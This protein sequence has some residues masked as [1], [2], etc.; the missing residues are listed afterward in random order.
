MSGNLDY[1][2]FLPGRFEFA[3]KALTKAYQDNTDALNRT[4][5]H[6][7]LPGVYTSAPNI[8]GAKNIQFQTAF[9]S[10][11]SIRDLI[12]YAELIIP[13]VPSITDRDSLA[14]ILL[15]VASGWNELIV[16]D[17]NDLNDQYK[18]IFTSYLSRLN[19]ILDGLQKFL[20]ELASIDKSNPPTWFHQTLFD[21]L[22]PIL[23]FASFRPGVTGQSSLAGILGLSLKTV[24]TPLNEVL[25]PFLPTKPDPK[26]AITEAIQT[27]LVEAINQYK[28][29][30]EDLI[31]IFTLFA[32]ALVMLSDEQRAIVPRIKENAPGPK[33]TTGDQCVAA[34]TGVKNAATT[35]IHLLSGNTDSTSSTTTPAPK[36]FQVK[37][38]A[39][40]SAPSSKSSPIAPGDVTAAF[41]PPSMAS[42]TLPQMGTTTGQIVMNF[43]KILTLPFIDQL[44]VTDAN[45]GET[46]VY[47]VMLNCKKK[48]EKL[49][50]TTVSI[51]RDLNSYGLLQEL[52]LPSINA[53]TDGLSLKDFLD[54]NLPLVMKYGQDAAK[55]AADTQAL[56]DEFE[57][58]L[59]ILNKNLD[60]INKSITEN[61][62]KL[63]EAQK[64][65]DSALANSIINSILAVVY[66]SVALASLAM[67]NGSLAIGMGISAGQNFAKMIVDAVNAG[68]LA[69]VIGNLKS[70]IATSE[71]TR[72]KLQIIIPLFRSIITLMA[73]IHT[74]WETISDDLKDVQATYD[75]WNNP[76]W[77]TADTVKGAIENWIDVQL[78]CQRYI[79]LV[80]GQIG[81]LDTAVAFNPG[82]VAPK[83]KAN[84]FA[85]MASFA[86][87]PAAPPPP[88][89]LAVLPGYESVLEESLD[90]ANRIGKFRALVQASDV[91]HLVDAL[92]PPAISLGVNRSQLN[93]AANSYR[94]IASS[95]SGLFDDSVNDA[96]A[97]ASTITS[98][99]IPSLQTAISFYITFADGQEDPFAKGTSAGALD[100][101]IAERYQQLQQGS[102]LS[103]SAETVFLNFRS[104]SQLALNTLT[105]HVNELNQ[106]LASKEASLRDLQAEYDKWSWVIYWPIPP[107]I[108]AI[109]YI[110]IDSITDTTNSINRLKN[111]IARLNSTQAY[112]S[113]IQSVSERVGNTTSSLSQSWSDLTTKTQT[114][115]TYVHAIVI[116]PDT[117]NIIR[118][119]V[120]NAWRAF[121]NE[122]KRW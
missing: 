67:G 111:D 4:Y 84:A 29:M 13:L 117:E 1:S 14:A 6:T 108:G 58:W 8:V 17:L 109:I 95:L 73:T 90:P 47:N 64:A 3:L 98:T 74:V 119:I 96:N 46:S 27:H 12:S 55:I 120:Q 80:S 103:K 102:N 36:P 31:P 45:Q 91:N 72:D 35:F 110:I 30:V 38:L 33:P 21:T 11:D 87:T 37:D 15:P 83:L 50:E 71:D 89:D 76:N 48:Y 61:Q 51:V 2:S 121:S 122:L 79:S 25:F 70:I 106:Q 22:V 107:G 41:G 19:P 60:E 86:A 26:T 81:S 28:Q 10:L 32:D 93:D 53:P 77:F 105:R 57:G 52:I 9:R 18:A 65:Y 43:N 118:P 59:Q 42:Q 85:T 40:H 44:K 97:L 115:E 39:V 7:V 82:N 78:Q 92:S 49:Q 88:Y 63:E 94:Q 75:L 116:N 101:M 100:S 112:V 23:S 114:L 68:K 54:T 24:S 62:G 113:N 5:L 69:V 20:S 99:L 56:L 66:T 16:S 104:A 34:W